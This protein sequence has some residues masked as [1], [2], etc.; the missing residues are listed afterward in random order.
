[1]KIISGIQ[2]LGVGVKDVKTAWKWYKEYFGMDVR[3][4][5]EA[6]VAELMLPY[7]GGQPQERH[8]ALALNMQGGGGFEIWQYTKRTPQAPK[9]KPSVGDLGIFSG[10]IKVKNAQQSFNHFVNK[11][12]TVI[13]KNVVEL[14]N[15]TKYFFV[16]DPAGNVF[17]L[18][19]GREWFLD[20]GKPTGAIAGAIVGVS[21]ID[22]ALTVYQDILN[23]DN[24]VYDKEG[25]FE[26]LAD[27][28]NGGETFRRVL[29]SHSE[30]R[31]G[32]F[33]EM[34]GSSTIELIEVKSRTPEKIF[35]DRFWGDLGFIHLCFDIS[36]MD[37]IREECKAK[38]FPFTVDSTLKHSDTFDMGEAAGQFTYIADPDGTLIEF[39]ETHKIPIVKKL[40]WFLDLRK[41]NAAKPLPKWMLSLIRFSKASDI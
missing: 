2:Q 38:G 24:I 40:G 12:Q 36:G 22:K 20:Q 16:E 31:K 3:M 29:L 25:T 13:S 35:K 5:E 26:D 9:N 8:A 33:S 6:A 39:V 17:R 27:L 34:F 15:G 21:D 14:P 28:T 1:M 37:D 7:T 41:R 19:E 30:K 4:F 23:Y 10:V 11:N 32:A 18:E